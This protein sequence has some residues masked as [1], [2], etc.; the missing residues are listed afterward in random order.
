MG[1]GEQRIEARTPRLGAG[2]DVG[3]LVDDLVPMACCLPSHAARKASSR[4][5]G[6]ARWPSHKLQPSSSQQL[7]YASNQDAAGYNCAQPCGVCQGE[8]SGPQVA[9]EVLETAEGHAGLDTGKW[10]HI[11][12]IH[13]AVRISRG[14]VKAI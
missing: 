10:F 1:A 4:C 9:L 8:C 12:D 3:V 7:L 14:K 6:R 11:Y 2:A 5:T 13:R